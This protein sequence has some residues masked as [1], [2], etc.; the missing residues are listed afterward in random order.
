MEAFVDLVASWLVADVGRHSEL[1]F[2]VL[3]EGRK[4]LISVAI[5][6]VVVVIHSSKVL[7]FHVIIVGEIVEVLSCLC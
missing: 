5:L 6:S 7:I 2:I 3:K 1:Q 4:G